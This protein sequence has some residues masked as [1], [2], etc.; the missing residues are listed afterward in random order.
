[1]DEFTWR[2]MLAKLN[3]NI[4]DIKWSPGRHSAEVFYEFSYHPKP[5]KVSWCKTF[6]NINGEYDDT[7]GELPITEQRFV[8]HLR[9]EVLELRRELEV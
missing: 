8:D 2:A 7:V 1:M 9:S 3:I 6:T 4:L 5:G